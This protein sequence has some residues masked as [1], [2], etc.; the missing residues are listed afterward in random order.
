MRAHE[1]PRDADAA[2]TRL[3]DDVREGI[4]Y[5]RATPWLRLGLLGG[6]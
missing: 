4:A 3:R 2:P 1:P 5:V 6:S